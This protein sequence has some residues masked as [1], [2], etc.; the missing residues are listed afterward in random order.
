MHIDLFIALCNLPA[1]VDLVMVL[2]ISNPADKA[3]WDVIVRWTVVFGAEVKYD[4]S[5][6]VDVY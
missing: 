1:F 3:C 4:S 2:S 5:V 6:V